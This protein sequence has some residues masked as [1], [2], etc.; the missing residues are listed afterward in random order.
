MEFVGVECGGEG[1]E[2]VNVK[3]KHFGGLLLWLG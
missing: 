2:N 1:R 3:L